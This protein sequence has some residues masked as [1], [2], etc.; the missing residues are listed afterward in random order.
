MFLIFDLMT[1]KF[2]CF[3]FS[4]LRSSSLR[5]IDTNFPQETVRSSFL[6]CFEF[7][8]FQH[9]AHT[10]LRR[11]RVPISSR[12]QTSPRKRRRGVCESFQAN[13]QVRRRAMSLLAIKFILD[14]NWVK[15]R[16]QINLFLLRTCPSELP[17]PRELS[18]RSF[19]IVTP[20]LWNN[21]PLFIRKVHS[22]NSFKQSGLKRTDLFQKTSFS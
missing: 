3:K 1:S 17:I 2:M 16:L 21:F 22:V 11:L 19:Y 13:L 4:T 15:S 10:R 7:F 9:Q 20:K 8:G 12:A 6:I 14:R 5:R 18:D